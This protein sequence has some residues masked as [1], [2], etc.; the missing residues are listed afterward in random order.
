MRV[1][2]WSKLSAGTQ[3]ATNP[4]RMNDKTCGSAR[5]C[6]LSLAYWAGCPF[7]LYLIYLHSPTASRYPQHVVTPT[8]K[9][10]MLLDFGSSPSDRC[11]KPV[12]EHAPPFPTISEMAQGDTS[13]SNRP[14]PRCLLFG[15][16]SEELQD[17]PVSFRLWFW[18]FGM[19]GLWGI[20]RDSHHGWYIG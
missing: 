4:C 6:A 11:V 15:H 14:W 19:V 16:G 20:N 12:A 5:Q 17:L 13:I 8:F 3:N 7:C 9:T 1:N 10:E 2:M 18:M